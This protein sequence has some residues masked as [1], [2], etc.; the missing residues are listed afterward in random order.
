MSMTSPS[1]APDN[2]RGHIN[3]RLGALSTLM[4][5]TREPPKFADVRAAIRRSFGEVLF[6]EKVSVLEAANRH[7]NLRNPGAYSG[8]WGESPESDEH[9]DDPM[10]N[11]AMSSPYNIVAVIGPSQTG[12]SEIGNNWQV[13]SVIYDPADIGFWAP[14]EKLTASYVTTQID[15]LLD[16]CPDVK[17]RQLSTASADNIALKQF[18]GC[19]WHFLWPTGPNFRARPFS[20]GRQDDY[21]D[22]DDDIGGQG[23]AV[24]LF[25]GRTTSFLSY[26]WK[27]YVNSS[28]KK[29]PKKGIEPLVAGGTSKRRWVDCLQ[30]ATPFQLCHERLSFRKDGTALDARNSACVVCPDCGFPHLQAHKAPLLATGRWIGKGETAV[31]FSSGNNAG[32]FGEIEPNSVDS[33]WFEGVFGFAPWPDLAEGE[34]SAELMFE[35]HQD[36][37]PLKS[38]YQTKVGRNYVSRSSGDAPVTI[39]ALTERARASGYTMGVVPDGVIAITQTV[40]LGIDRF[41]VMTVGHGVG[42]RAWIIDR[43]DILT[44][45]DGV[46]KLEPFRRREHWAVLYEKVLSRTY[47][48]QRDPTLRMKVFCTGVDTGGSDDAT[49][50]AYAWWHDMVTGSRKDG[51]PALPTTAIT[52]L[53]G[54][55]RP[56]G[57]LLPAPTV[58]AKRQ[59]KGL[60]ECELFVPNVN[61]L[62]DMADYR[63]RRP[64]PGPAYVD[65]PNDFPD[66]RIAELRAEEKVEGLWEKP[67]GVRN[68]SWDLFVYAIAV[69]LRLVGLDQN[70]TRVPMWARPPKARAP[71][72]APPPEGT[73]DVPAPAKRPVVQVTRPNQTSPTPS[74]PKPRRTVRMVRPS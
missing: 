5:Q 61:R 58:D 32:K 30:C 65:L 19:D 60:P 69:M 11:L 47:P 57:R 22:F 39:D 18:K 9:L 45:N 54:G 1:P 43:F 28:P 67:E 21:D 27:L 55:N 52:L 66:K 37:Q 31:S 4:Q 62:K 33:Y 36:E 25:K 14:T 48:L 13:H 29:G 6:P 59:V 72:R 26:G 23:D 64:E 68:E 35:E 24:S 53:K 8:P 41:S 50:N 7:R 51:R 46:T 56:N 74:R 63:F 38:Y 12:K 71:E 44:L 15:K 34:R 17:A 3:I 20:R 70:L 49:D 16:E 2:D 42:N 10:N 73:P 40:D